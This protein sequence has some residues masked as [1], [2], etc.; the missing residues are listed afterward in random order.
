MRA[1]TIE[2]PRSLK[3]TKEKLRPALNYDAFAP[4]RETQNFDQNFVFF[5]PWQRFFG[6][7]RNSL[8]HFIGSKKVPL[9]IITYTAPGFPK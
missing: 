8:R 3:N 7:V 9:I 5:Y 6:E 2:M 4:L 1:V